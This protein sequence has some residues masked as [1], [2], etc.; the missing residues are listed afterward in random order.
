MNL[1]IT[2]FKGTLSFQFVGCH[3]AFT[4]NS[5]R[6]LMCGHSVLPCGKSSLLQKYNH[7]MTCQISR[8][9]RMHSEVRIAHHWQNQTCAH[10]KYIKSCWNAGH[11]TQSSEQHSRNF[12]SCLLPITLISNKYMV[13]VT[14]KKCMRNIIIYT[15][16]YQQ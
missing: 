2:A 8:L 7:T 15:L 9:L 16:I 4:V 13:M 1:T 3:M 12:F 14:M 5:P 10:S 6:N 11:T